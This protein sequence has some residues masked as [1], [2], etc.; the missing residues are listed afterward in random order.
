MVNVPPRR[1]LLAAL[2]LLA[3][4]GP[5]TAVVVGGGNPETDCSV[6]F[7]GVDQNVGT[8]GVLCTDGDPACD[9]DGEANG[10]CRFT[11][12]LCTHVKARSCG[13]VDLTAVSVAGRSL[14]LPPLPSTAPG[15]GAP[16]EVQVEVGK[17]S[18]TTLLAHAGANLR[19]VDYLNLCCV[20]QPAPYAAA[21]CALHLALSASGCRAALLPKALRIGLARARALAARA[22][23]RPRRGRAAAAKAVD[24][25]DGLTTIAH[26]IARRDECG[27]ALGLMLSHARWALAHP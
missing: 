27:D 14:P 6:A 16:V 12:S 21:A 19:D 1:A 17:P 24:V 10:V 4:T 26:R 9:A 18:E 22:A 7:T 25:L 13:A 8:S 23:R 3:S 2:C 20:A 15:C 11:V 5:A